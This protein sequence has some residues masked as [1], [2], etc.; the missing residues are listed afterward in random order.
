MSTNNVYE[1]FKETLIRDLGDKYRYLR[2]NTRI[3]ENYPFN[4]G[5][6]REPSNQCDENGR[7]KPPHLNRFGFSGPGES[8]II[9]MLLRFQDETHYVYVNMSNGTFQLTGHGINHLRPVIAEL[10]FNHYFV[11]FV[12]HLETFD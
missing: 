1:S 6:I 5:Q 3:Y 11:H 2:H 9:D 7:L 12:S 4:I 10:L 8:L